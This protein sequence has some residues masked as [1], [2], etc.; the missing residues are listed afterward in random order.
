LRNFETIGEF[1]LLS[2]FLSISHHQ[3]TP[4]CTTSQG[5]LLELKLVIALV[6]G[7]KLML[8]LELVLELGVE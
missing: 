6:R 1:C 4:R 3:L 8:A 5:L 2:S 7:Y